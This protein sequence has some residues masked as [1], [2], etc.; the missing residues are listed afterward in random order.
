MIWEKRPSAPGMAAKPVRMEEANLHTGGGKIW[1][2]IGTIPSSYGIWRKRIYPALWRK[3][4]PRVTMGMKQN[5]GCG[6]RISR[7]GG[8][9]L[10]RRNMRAARRDM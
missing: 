4:E 10:W 1:F 6:F 8:P 5:S 7:K 2:T 3:K 9:L